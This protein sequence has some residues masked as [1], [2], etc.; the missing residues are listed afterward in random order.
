MLYVAIVSPSV[1]VTNSG[2]VISSCVR[3]KSTHTSDVPIP[4]SLSPI[5]TLA[6]GYSVTT[7]TFALS[8]NFLTFFLYISAF[9]VSGSNVISFTI[10]DDTFTFYDFLTNVNLYVMTSPDSDVTV[11]GIVL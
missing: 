11:N 3:L 9:V 7:F 10:T 2:T 1:A 6:Y 8:A 4:S 5:F